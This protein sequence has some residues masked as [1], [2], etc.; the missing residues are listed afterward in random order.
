MSNL[1]SNRTEYAKH[2]SNFRGVDFSSDHTNVDDRRFAYAVNM[3]KDYQSAQGNAI[4]TIPGFRQRGAT[5]SGAIYGIHR[6]KHRDSDGNIVQKIVIHHGTSL[7]L[8]TPEHYKT[9]VE[10]GKEKQ[11]WVEDAFTTISLPKDENDD[12]V[13]MNNHKSTSFVFNNRL[14]ILDGKN[15]LVYDGNQIQTVAE[16]AYV[17]SVY[18]NT[19]IS[20]EN[21]NAGTEYEQRNLLS[22]YFIQTF[23]P[24]GKKFSDDDD[25]VKT[26]WYEL[27][28]PADAIVSVEWN[29]TQYDDL[30]KTSGTLKGYRT[31][32]NGEGKVT[33]IR[34]EGVVPGAS[35]VTLVKIKARTAYPRVQ[36]IIEGVSDNADTTSIISE[37]TIATVFDNRVF[38]SGN[39]K[40]PNH[41][42]YSN[43][44]NQT[45]YA[46]TSYWGAL[47][48][49]QEGIGNSP[50][51]AMVPLADSLLVL[52]SDTQQDGSIY[53][54][55][56]YETGE[57]LVPVIY[58]STP[59]LNGTGCLGAAVNFLDD[60]IFISRFGVEGIGQLSVRYERAIEH[61][62]SLI[63][64][65]LLNT[66]LKNACLEEWNG[67]LIL[68]VDG[69]IFMADS[70]QR[71]THE[72]G[73][74]QY[75]WYYL[76][77]I[78]IYKGQSRPKGVE[79]FT[80]GNFSPAVIVREIDGNLFFGTDEGHL[81]SF[82]FDK[83]DPITREIPIKWYTFDGRKIFSGCA[84]KMDCC[85]IPH[86]TKSTVNR[87]TVI[88]TKKLSRAA[89]KIAVRTNKNPFNQIARINSGSLNFEDIN[90]A[91]FTMEQTIFAL[92]E[93]EKQWV[94][95]QYYVYSDEF[96]A[97]F[98]LFYISYRY[99]VAGRI[100]TQGG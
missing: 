100:K 54:H 38:L 72:T 71:Y 74:M 6:F 67:Y 19:I 41:V 16:N 47:N 97:P 28:I 85:G 68:L 26:E 52:K 86:L 40:Y 8:F 46:D 2:Y 95:K 80:G 9:V 88:K 10:D 61:R 60:P 96:Q 56:R 20:G 84:T 94:E 89:A 17:P 77:D 39:P 36:G 76:E 79:E 65:V 21:A 66:N 93:K 64:A 78:G 4:E 91:D 82:N 83:R 90:F 53:Y 27:S 45:G 58:P 81:C 24:D 43:I 12:D 75:E 98:A 37:C 14:H 63:D 57:N 11:E 48:Y 35:V 22:P 31:D 23:C 49:F 42:F 73:V 30:D 59:G 3:Y 50:V 7:S 34:F 15:F 13:V 51:T 92:K 62:S 70:R 69:K 32:T 18:I 99:Y 33:K 5:L 25:I 44:N 1:T 55:K 87:S 29:E